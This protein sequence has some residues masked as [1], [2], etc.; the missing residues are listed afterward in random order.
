[1]KKLL[2]LFLF[3][4]ILT[5]AQVIKLK[6][7]IKN[8]D[9]KETIPYVNIGVFENAI[10]TVSN[11]NGYF[12]ISIDADV[13]GMNLSFSHI[14]YKQYHISINYEMSD[15][16]TIL[17]KPKEN[18][19]TEIVVYGK[20]QH[21]LGK[22]NNKNS[23]KG[24]FEPK[25][26]GGEAGTLIYNSGSCN[27]QSFNMNVLKN[28]FEELTFRLNFYSIKTKKPFQKIAPETIF[29][30]VENQE[31]LITINLEQKNIKIKGSFIVSIEL[32]NIK[33]SEID[34][35]EFLFSAYQEKGAIAYRKMISMG[36]WEKFKKVGLCYWIKIEK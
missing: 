7:V 17:L 34:N 9:T 27:V 21:I 30:V 10:G 4:P 1:M 20:K 26:L 28:N 36:K 35:P 16:L 6:G 11:E 12:E 5:T 15:S 13:F 8:A 23:I 2:L 3:L 29:K 24:F 33:N 31:G 18:E 25:G 14:N 32:I 22:K 19:L